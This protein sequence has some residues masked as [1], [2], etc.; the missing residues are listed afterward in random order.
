MKNK[1]ETNNFLMDLNKNLHKYL[2]VVEKLALEGSIACDKRFFD[3]L[4]KNAEKEFDEHNDYNKLTKHK[5]VYINKNRGISI[6]LSKIIE[7][8]RNDIYINEA[9]VFIDNAS[10]TI[11][12][13]EYMGKDDLS[14]NFNFDNNRA[15][16]KFLL[17]N[18]DFHLCEVIRIKK[19][20]HLMI[21]DADKYEIAT[22]Y[23][24]MALM[25]FISRCRLVDCMY[26]TDFDIYSQKQ[27]DDKQS[28]YNLKYMVQY[29]EKKDYLNNV[30]LEYLLH[31]PYYDANQIYKNK[32]VKK[33]TKK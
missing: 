23:R 16:V 27:H 28:D 2:Y 31:I 7:I 5:P 22:M 24:I 15:L 21:A 8:I 4:V 1:K 14:I 6:D 11:K 33:K 9:Y 32:K 20:N 17:D 12:H 10:K 13:V 3:E 29:K 25:Q 30:K 18:P 26:I 19:H